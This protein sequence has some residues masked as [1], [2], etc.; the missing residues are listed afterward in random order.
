MSEL[1][2]QNSK[3][4]KIVREDYKKRSQV[5]VF[6]EFQGKRYT[7]HSYRFDLIPDRFDSP[8][9]SWA[10]LDCCGGW[11]FNEKY[12]DTAVQK[13]K[14]LYAGR[15]E[16]VKSSF[17]P[18]LPSMDEAVQEFQKIVDGL[19]S[20]IIAGIESSGSR[21]DMKGYLYTFICREGKITDYFDL[22]KVFEFYSK[23]GLNFP[24]YVVAQ[25][26]E[27]CDIEIKTFGGNKPPFLY[28]QAG[29][30]VELI[31]TGLLLGYPLE[32]T[33]SILCGY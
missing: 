33:A 17:S 28:Y 8:F 1:L 32:S 7:L 31:T 29:T 19:S 4:V 26:K 3:G 11:S 5:K 14:K 12:L 10:N 16:F 6:S 13:G 24:Q 18:D 27:L 2:H 30:P 20:G 9:C 21:E 22:N 23:L 15:V 25:V